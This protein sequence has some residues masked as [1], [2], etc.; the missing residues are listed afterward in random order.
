MGEINFPAELIK[1]FNDAFPNVEECDHDLYGIKTPADILAGSAAAEK[2]A[3]AIRDYLDAAERVDLD[4]DKAT[5]DVFVYRDASAIALSIRTPQ[6][7]LP[8]FSMSIGDLDDCSYTYVR[9]HYEIGIPSGQCALIRAAHPMMKGLQAD[10]LKPSTWIGEGDEEVL[11]KEGDLPQANARLREIAN[12][13]KVGPQLDTPA[14]MWDVLG[15]P[16]SLTMRAVAGEKI[17]IQASPFIR[18]PGE[19]SVQPID[20]ETLRSLISS[21][22][23]PGQIS[24][25]RDQAGR[26]KK[27]LL[28]LDPAFLVKEIK[29][30]Y[31][32]ITNRTDMRG[33]PTYTQFLNYAADDDL[34]QWTAL[35]PNQPVA[36]IGEMTDAAGQR[37][38]HALAYKVQGWIRAEDVALV[39]KKEAAR[40]WNDADVI[41]VTAPKVVL[42]ARLF[43]MGTRLNVVRTPDANKGS[44]RVLIANRNA[45]TG[46]LKFT[47]ADIPSSLVTKDASASPYYLGRVPYSRANMVRLLFKY[48]GTPWAMANERRG[49]DIAFPN[50]GGNRDLYIDCSG[51]LEKAMDAM[52]L[53]AFSRS[54]KWQ[55]RQGDVLWDKGK[56]PGQKPEDV[57]NSSGTGIWFIGMPGHI[58]FYLGKKG[59]EYWMIHSPGHF[60][61]YVDDQGNFVR[62]GDGEAIVSQITLSSLNAKFDVLTAPVSLR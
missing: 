27:A 25:E 40:L 38:Y 36:V 52:G 26:P 7:M 5:Q 6:G 24:I 3:V 11:I 37:W 46:A 55:A 58:M 62:T 47:H 33:I 32:W 21:I 8:L 18:K 31:G 61:T 9:D 16:K 34:Y 35:N 17:E 14:L 23:Y 10:Y 13:L 49:D 1:K 19:S 44:F 60:R 53:Y 48:L 43:E 41:T 45:K 50:G 12:G 54:S 30:R 4:G 51:I 2:K 28:T 56:N 15:L 42:D 20:E 22:G 29:P 59:D 57:L 39:S